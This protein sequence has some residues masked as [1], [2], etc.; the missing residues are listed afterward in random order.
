MLDWI[1]G[2]V[3]LS[4]CS[5]LAFYIILKSLRFRLRNPP[6]SYQKLIAIASTEDAPLPASIRTPAV[7]RMLIQ[8]TRKPY[9]LTNLLQMTAKDLAVDVPIKKPLIYGFFHPN[10]AAFGGGERVLWCAVKSLLASDSSAVAAIYFAAAK[11]FD[12]EETLGTVKSRFGVEFSS[13]EHDRIVFIALSQCDLVKP[14]TYPILTLLGQA[15]GQAILGYEAI[16]N[17]M[18]DVFIDTTGLAFSFPVVSWFAKIPIVAYVHYPFVQS[19]MLNSLHAKITKPKTV[20]KY[21]YYT[22]LT[23]AYKFVGSYADVVSVNG[24]WTK[25]LLNWSQSKRIIFPPCAV[26]DFKAPNS[27]ESEPSKRSPSFVYVAQFRPEKRHAL[28]LLEFAEALKIAKKDRKLPR[29]NIILIG[30]VRNEEDAAY[31]RN[32]HKV[33]AACHLTTNDYAIV[34]NAPWYAVK[35]IMEKSSFGLNAMW[36]EHFG[37]GVVEIMAAGLIPI[38]NATGGP[39]LDIVKDDEGAPGFFF[40][41]DL[42]PDFEKAQK[43]H[44]FP[45]LSEAM[46]EALSLPEEEKEKLR[47]RCFAT[48]QRFSDAVFDKAWTEEIER[49]APKIVKKSEERKKLKLFD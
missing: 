38:V 6:P 30:S 13:K 11:Q 22:A 47:M 23:L 17:L 41:T 25:N 4:F 21:L 5:A 18:P 12:A 44:K 1:S 43:V 15:I 29:P 39:Y 31:V 2:I 3:F 32:L 10:A 26:Q 46:I 35:L 45:K 36:N 49:V 48:S 9:K 16:S 34:E 37:M 19:A 14:E 24:T 20:I 7:R 33:A 27:T 40:R 42:D 28:A 8:S